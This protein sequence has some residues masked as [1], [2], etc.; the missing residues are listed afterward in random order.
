MI[1]IIKNRANKGEVD[2]ISGPGGSFRANNGLSKALLG[3]RGG[4]S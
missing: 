4:S 2:R 3:G 1:I